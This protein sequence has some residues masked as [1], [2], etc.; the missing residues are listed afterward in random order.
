MFGV[1]TVGR[2]KRK[3][4]GAYKPRPVHGMSESYGNLACNL[5]YLTCFT[6][7]LDL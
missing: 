4:E 1:V 2:V 7:V 3:G 6:Q 5:L